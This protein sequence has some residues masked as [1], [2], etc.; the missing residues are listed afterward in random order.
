[1][2]YSKY[3]SNPKKPLLDVI[4]VEPKQWLEELSKA[5]WWDWFEGI[6]AI[7]SH[8]DIYM[9]QRAGKAALKALKNAISDRKA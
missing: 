7:M 3:A 8:S 9:C 2:R 1:M 4:D 6:G 5:D